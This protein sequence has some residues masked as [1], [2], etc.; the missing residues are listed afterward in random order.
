MK[1]NRLLSVFIIFFVALAAAA[2]GDSVPVRWRAFV[3]S[4]PDGTGVVVLRALIEPGWH[5]YSTDI[6]EGGPK[7]TSFDFSASEGIEFTGNIEASRKPVATE[8]PLFGMTLKWWD[9]KVEFERPF[10]I[11][12]NKG[13]IRCKISFMSCDGSTCRPP[14]SETISLTVNK[15]N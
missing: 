13:T 11:T 7:A 4:N 9:E 1:I 5:L 8:D 12:G 14:S 10:K 6:P 2:S 3:K 15:N